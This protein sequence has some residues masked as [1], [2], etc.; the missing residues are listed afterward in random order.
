ML[1]ILTATSAYHIG[2]ICITYLYNGLLSLDLE[3]L[4]LSHYSVSQSNIDNLG[5]LGELDVLEDDEWSVD[6]E[7]SSV[8]DS[9]CD[10]VVSGG[11]QEVIHF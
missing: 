6:I 9:G 1:L 4:T 5:I 10:V 8:V 3:D 2:C 11:G 7:D